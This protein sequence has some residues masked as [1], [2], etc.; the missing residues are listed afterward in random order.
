[1]TKLYYGKEK[2]T[3]SKKGRLSLEGKEKAKPKDCFSQITSDEALAKVSK[4]YVPPNTEKNNA[5]SMR[6]FERWQE[7]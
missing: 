7:T 4:G 6:V 1:V 3:V 5:W 2:K